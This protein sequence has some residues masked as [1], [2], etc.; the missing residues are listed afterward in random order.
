M[1]FNDAITPSKLPS[2]LKM[3]NMKAV[4]KKGAIALKETYKPTNILPLISTI[5]GRIVCKQL[6]IFC[7]DILSKY[8]CR[9]RK[10]LSSQ[11]CLFLML[12]KWRKAVDNKEAFVSFL[13]DISKAFDC[14]HH[15]L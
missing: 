6:I 9:F 13:T 7:D 12:E 14:L 11:H 4:F 2:S 1:I 15:E 10:G 3:G 8:Q 5:L